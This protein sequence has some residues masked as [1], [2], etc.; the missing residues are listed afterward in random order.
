MKV[1]ILCQG[2]RGDV[3][4]FAALAVALNAAG[5]EV[6]LGAPA[7]SAFLVAPYD[8][9]FISFDDTVSRLMADPEVRKGFQQDYRGLHGKKLAI[10]F[11]LK[12]RKNAPR[13]LADMASASDDGADLVV[14][15]VGL[16]GHLVA[17]LLGVPSVPACPYPSIIP[18]NSF[19]HP[20]FPFRLPRALNRATYLPGRQ[21]LRALT[22]GTA[23]WRSETLGL[24]PRR[25][26]HNVLRRADG[27]YVTALQAFSQH[28]LPAPLNYPAWVH[29][30]GFW[31]LPT[32]P[33]WEP[34]RKLSDFLR[35]GDPPIY[36]GFGSVVGSDPRRTGRTVIEAIRRAQVRA[37]V[38]KG[39]GGIEAN[40]SSD[41]VLYIDQA[42]HDWLFPRMAAIVHHGGSGTTGAALASGRP[43]VVCP[44]VADQPFWGQR[45]HAVGVAPAPQPQRRL[46]SDS[47][48]EAIHLASTDLAMKT[49]AATLGRQVSDES[50][51]A[52]AVKILESQFTT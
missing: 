21:K 6:T 10:Q 49:N 2:S 42:P 17:E 23:K 16:P 29:T 4:P 14:H 32:A 13:I 48:A 40:D 47:L 5:H 46:T 44:F 34:P 3:Q 15:H 27:T 9:R 30:T 24:P 36:I 11:K 20:R 28:V 19:P 12:V 43:Q 51:V 35:A 26:Y 22:L 52:T 41:H 31:F 33:D 45:M 38:A 8:V 1:L 37:I 25:G 39:W 50:G 7:K 18:T